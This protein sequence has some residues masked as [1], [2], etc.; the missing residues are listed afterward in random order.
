M[1]EKKL[2]E[3]EIDL[4]VIDETNRTA[5]C[6]DYIMTEILLRKIKER[7]ERNRNLLKIILK[8]NRWD[9]Y[10]DDETQVSFT[11]S[12][13]KRETFDKTQLEYIL[14]PTQM[15]QVTK[16]TTYEKLTVITPK[17]RKELNKIVRKEKKL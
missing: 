14:T 6:N 13:L 4:G 16:I 7:Q 17:R 2:K 3:I 5:I 9:R 8:E 10:V 15:V 11:L 12:K 1:V